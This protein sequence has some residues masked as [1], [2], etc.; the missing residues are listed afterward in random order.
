MNIGS[1]L[2]GLR[3]FSDTSQPFVGQQYL[4]GFEGSL[5]P[6]FIKIAIFVFKE[7]P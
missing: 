3:A 7:K 4:R 5:T 2:K 6:G 1:T